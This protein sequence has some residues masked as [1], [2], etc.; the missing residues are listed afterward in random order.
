MRHSR[1]WLVSTCI[2][3]LSYLLISL[4][5]ARSSCTDSPKIRHDKLHVKAIHTGSRVSLFIK[6]HGAKIIA[7]GHKTNPWKKNQR[8]IFRKTLFCGLRCWKH[9]TGNDYVGR[10][11]SYSTPGERLRPWH[12][13]DHESGIRLYSTRST[14]VVISTEVI[15]F[16]PCDQ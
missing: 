6:I 5:V 8:F 1:Y 12:A 7:C 15:C 10:V 14:S 4:L 13:G 2:L 3:S 11:W 16:W 9:C